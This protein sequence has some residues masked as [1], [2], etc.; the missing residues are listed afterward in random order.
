MRDAVRRTALFALERFLVRGAH[1][2]FLFVVALIGLVSISGGML[3]VADGSFEGNGDAIWWAFLRL[4]DPG[5]LGDDQGL[6]KRIVSTV[7]TV[8]GYVVFLGA[9]VAILTQWL[10]STLARLELGLTPIRMNGHIVVVGWTNRTAIICRDL[11]WSE[12]R[13]QRW[14]ALRGV[15]R[16]RIAI[17]S[18]KIDPSRVQELQRTIGARYHRN[19]VVLRSGSPLRTSD[20]ARIDLDHAASVV[21]PGVEATSSAAEAHDDAVIKTLCVVGA[22]SGEGGRLP[23]CICE[24]FD[25]RK[26]PVA[27]RAYPGDLEVVA[28]DV[29][30]GRLLAYSMREPG[31][32][33]VCTELLTHGEGATFYIHSWDEPAAAFGEIRSR[34]TGAIA[35]GVVHDERRGL[36]CRL[37]PSPEEVV[38]RG[39]R[40]VVVARTYD[41]IRVSSDA[42]A[43][44]TYELVELALR[45]PQGGRILI[46]GWSRRV[47]HLLR[48]LDRIAGE[49][50]AVTLLS[51][52]SF[53]EREE[54]LRSHDIELAN[55]D[56][57]H[58]RGDITLPASL[59]ELDPGGFDRV[60]VVASDWLASGGASDARSIS[61]YHALGKVL[62]EGERRP[63]LVME[64]SDPQ[65]VALFDPSQAEVVV[66]PQVLSHL[67]AQIVLRRDLRVVVDDIFG[68]GPSNLRFVR[69]SGEGPVA[70]GAISEAIRARGAIA[71]GLRR[72]GIGEKIQLMPGP[73]ESLDGR[74]ADEVI[75]LSSAPPTQP[76]PNEPLAPAPETP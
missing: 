7:L 20:L 1:Y 18:P 64:L 49:R 35:L 23:S 24:I 55:L 13:L 19:R 74:R 75:V 73:S 27:K 56:L 44:P 39:D 41:Q 32:A 71:I 58:V 65:N 34:V 5:Y 16:L 12:G 37:C 8:L 70:F 57:T 52:V 69:V 22:S 38:A 72:G 48:E 67:L 62:D 43:P 21:I 42:A 54:D 68:S 53:E 59:A 36:R 25:P 46:L 50:W 28:S 66:S 4:S 9:M 30:M 61:A 31:L 60:L 40:L 6:W 29:V 17:L 33:S 15:R 10:N 51:I 2:R 3:V 11:F 63:A 26:L 45:E 76:H 47:P 14:L